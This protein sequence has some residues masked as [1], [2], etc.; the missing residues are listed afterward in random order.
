MDQ[1]VYKLLKIRSVCEQ[2]L[3]QVESFSEEFFRDITDEIP[4]CWFGEGDQSVLVGLLSEVNHR[5]HRMR[6]LIERDLNALGFGMESG[7]S[8]PSGSC[9]CEAPIR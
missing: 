2:T 7:M 8:D 9:C 4:A 3:D 1:K 5:K 6:L